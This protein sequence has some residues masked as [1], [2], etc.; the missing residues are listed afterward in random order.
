M[1]AF[2]WKSIQISV[3]I[4]F[5]ILHRKATSSDHYHTS[6]PAWPG[7]SIQ[8]TRRGPFAESSLSK[9]WATFVLTRHKIVWAPYASKISSD[10]QFHSTSYNFTEIIGICR[11]LFYD[12]KIYKRDLR[13]DC[14]NSSSQLVWLIYTRIAVPGK[15]VQ[16]AG[17]VVLGSRLRI[18]LRSGLSY[19]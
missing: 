9:E 1:R 5:K 16:T 8:Q 7:I 12:E 14:Y 13:S 15:M 6:S 10:L 18:F 2:N 4:I 19:V 3:V 11:W 17:N